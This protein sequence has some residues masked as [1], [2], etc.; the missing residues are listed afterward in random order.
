[1]APLASRI[2]VLCPRSLSDRF[3]RTGMFLIE[4]KTA[5]EPP[6]DCVAPYCAVTERFEK[7][8]DSNVGS[9][10]SQTKGQSPPN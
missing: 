10:K 6:E 2:E 5:C 7:G 9:W 3:L 4:N 1:M 8:R